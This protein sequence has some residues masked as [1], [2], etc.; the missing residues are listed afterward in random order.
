MGRACAVREAA[1]SVRLD[2]MEAGLDTPCLT[3]LRLPGA[4]PSA[5][6]V[7]DDILAAAAQV[8]RRLG[9]AP[10]FRLGDEADVL[11]VPGMGCV[12]AE[13]LGQALARP[14][15]RAAVERIDRAMAS[16]RTVVA[17][18]A[19]VFLLAET[20]RLAGRRVTTS[21]FLAPLLKA[22]Y[23]RVE[24]A[25]DLMVVEDGAI[26]TGAAALAQGD[27]MAALLRRVCGAEIAELCSRYLLIGG[28]V[29]QAPF[30]DLG[31]LLA[32]DP[33]LSGLPD[34]VRARI[35]QPIAV[36]EL[37]R[38]ARLE[39]KTFSRRLIAACG[40]SPSKF[41]QR[42]RLEEASRLLQSGHLSFEQVALRIGYTDSS[43]LRR[44]LR[45]TQTGQSL[46]ASFS[47]EKEEPSL[48]IPAGRTAPRS[49]ASAT[50]AR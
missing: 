39:V 49:A 50:S 2:I 17:S 24:V 4:L 48:P 43:A 35:D 19:S 34:F 13:E 8:E 33:G 5:V 37:A 14:A 11:I 44:L 28:R 10:S 38:F 12:D 1:G 15:A 16:G 47:S 36:A 40:L 6:A 46:A 30:V 26:I 25:A 7:T 31:L 23:P 9:R 45:R 18:C 27:A 20:G 32:A 3:V 42:L 21:W 22:R 41:V 29:H